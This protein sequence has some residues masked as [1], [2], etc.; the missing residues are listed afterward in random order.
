[1]GMVI[2]H[3]SIIIKKE[4]A[5]FYNTKYNISSDIDWVINSL[6]K[7]KCIIN[8]KMILCKYLV[9]GKARQ[10][11]FK[12]NFERFLILT[13]HYGFFSTILN[14]F[15]FLLRFFKFYVLAKLFPSF[16]RN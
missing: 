2:S 3:Q 13:N 8:T 14:H 15:I 9:G 16:E 4:I 7:S 10:N 6:K 12:G 11:F 5:C 1:M